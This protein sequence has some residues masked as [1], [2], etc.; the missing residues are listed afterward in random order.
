YTGKKEKS[1]I[2]P[3]SFIETGIETDFLLCQM[4]SHGNAP[5]TCDVFVV[6]HGP[7]SVSVLPCPIRAR[8]MTLAQWSMIPGVGQKRA[9]R[10]KREYPRSVQEAESIVGIRLP[11][12]L[13]RW[14][15]FE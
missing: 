2:L 12:W 15:V 9:A 11:E 4:P 1:D 10:L 14:M 6:D 13:T 8:E 5:K 7:R 3:W